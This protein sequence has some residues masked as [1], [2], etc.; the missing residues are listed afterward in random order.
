MDLDTHC[1]E[2]PLFDFFWSYV[3]AIQWRREPSSI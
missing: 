3:F 1:L 2:G